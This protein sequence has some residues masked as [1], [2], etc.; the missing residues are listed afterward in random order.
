MRNLWL[1]MKILGLPF[2]LCSLL[3]MIGIALFVFI[4]DFFPP[5]VIVLATEVCL[6]LIGAWLGSR[7]IGADLDNEILE[8]SFA[9]PKF[10]TKGLIARILALVVVMI[11]H[12]LAMML[13][14]RIYDPP[15]GECYRL[16]CSTLSPTLFLGGCAFLLTAVLRSPFAAFSVCMGIWAANLS[17]QSIFRIRSSYS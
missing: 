16:L 14:H 11:I 3:V 2:A 1:S 9:Q 13:V 5:S 10:R 7:I 4:M 8:L 12:V 15:C 6:P 17:W